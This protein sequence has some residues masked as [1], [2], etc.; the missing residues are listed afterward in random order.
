MS[1]KFVCIIL[2]TGH[3]EIKLILNRNILPDGFHAR[4]QLMQD[5]EG[6]DQY[7]TQ[8]FSLWTKTMPSMARYAHGCNS[9]RNVIEAT[10]HLSGLKAHSIG[11]N[12]C[13]ALE[14]IIKMIRCSWDSVDQTDQSQSLSQHLPH[15]DILARS[16]TCL[17]AFLAI[18]HAHHHLSY[19]CLPRIVISGAGYNLIYLGGVYVCDFVILSS[20]ALNSQALGICPSQLLEQVQ[21]QMHIPS[22]GTSF[23]SLL[24][25]LASRRGCVEEGLEKHLLPVLT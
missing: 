11:G 5:V 10:S 23:C 20:L 18:H 4:R 14:N 3:G 19:P 1:L 7:P 16:F 9:E 13:Q 12:P 21:L 8:L 2:V 6:G 17:F 24:Y 25:I 22:L 15:L